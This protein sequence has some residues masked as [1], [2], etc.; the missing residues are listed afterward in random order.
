[1]S[2]VTENYNNEFKGYIYL[3]WHT[4]YK[5]LIKMGK[6]KCPV[7]RETGYIT[8]EVD[9]GNYIKIFRILNMDY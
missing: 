6:A 5:Q 7:E 8:G 3:R 1:M 2:D 9:R 4:A